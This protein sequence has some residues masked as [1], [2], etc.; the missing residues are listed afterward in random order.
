MEAVSRAAVGVFFDGDGG[1][2]DCVPG[3]SAQE[4]RR[5]SLFN[6][7][8]DS[9]DAEMG[10]ALGLDTAYGYHIE[11]AVQ[12]ADAFWG[13]HIDDCSSFPCIDDS[14]SYGGC[15]GAY[16][17]AKHC[18]AGAL[19]RSARHRAT[20]RPVE[21]RKGGM[22]RTCGNVGIDHHV[23]CKDGTELLTC[24]AGHFD[25]PITAS[26]LVNRRVPLTAPI[27]CND[28]WPAQTRWSAG[29]RRR[30]PRPAWSRRLF[31]GR[32]R[33]LGVRRRRRERISRG[34]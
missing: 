8:S 30:S 15:L 32:H 16:C 2:C 17:P 34:G 18:W 24:L 27:P 25:W 31:G 33:P 29:G 23:S 4:A 11:Y 3:V 21:Q 10:A 26:C 13:R 20:R 14:R 5:L 1:Q 9:A 19:V 22:C 6:S 7:D 28:Y 12:A